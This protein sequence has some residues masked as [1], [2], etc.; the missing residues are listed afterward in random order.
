MTH[1]VNT[2]L[3]KDCRH[4]DCVS[5]C[6]VACFRAGPDELYIKPSECIDCGV[7]VPECP[8]VAIY[9]DYEEVLPEKHLYFLKRN[10]EQAELWP[11]ITEME[12]PLI[13][14]EKCKQGRKTDTASG[15]LNV[16]DIAGD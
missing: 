1:I 8:E 13:Q 5:V 6:P 2:D 14:H 10:E 16:S 7:C 4:T 3:C 15:T 9:A 11:E 12:P